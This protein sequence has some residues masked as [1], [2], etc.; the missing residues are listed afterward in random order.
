[1]RSLESQ[2]DDHDDEGRDEDERLDER[3]VGRADGRLHGLADAGEGE[4]HLDDDRA[5]EQD[6]ELDRDAR[7]DRQAR[8]AQRVH[9]D[10]P[11]RRACRRRAGCACAP[12]SSDSPIDARV[13]RAMPAAE[14]I[15]IVST[16]RTSDLNHA[17]GLTSNGTKPV[18][19]S[20]RS[21]TAKT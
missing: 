13:W 14:V 17:S 4:E 20:S 5:A 12:A 8:A 18:A 3:Q 11:R 10:D 21:C 9:V 19:G 1:M 16:G 7:E 15:A 2:V 6:D